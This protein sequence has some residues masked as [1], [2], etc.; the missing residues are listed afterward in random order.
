M[1]ELNIKEIREKLHISQMEFAKLIGVHPRTVQNWESGSPIPKSK[2]AI[3][4]DLMSESTCITGNNNTSVAGN[5]NNV[6]CSSTI[7][8]AIDEIS[9]Q[10]KLLEK[11][12]E[13]IDRLLTIIEKLSDE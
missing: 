13:Q 1:N 2:Y 7:E 9:A 4:R 10:R 6:N 3:L 11:S 8:K 5:A 12:Q